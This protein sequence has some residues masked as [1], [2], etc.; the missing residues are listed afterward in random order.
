MPGRPERPTHRGSR[1]EGNHPSPW[2]EAG[3]SAKSRNNCGCVQALASS[4]IARK[5]RGDPKSIHRTLVTLQSTHSAH[6][7]IAIMRKSG[8]R[9]SFLELNV[10]LAHEWIIWQEGPRVTPGVSGPH[11]MHCSLESCKLGEWL[12]QLM[13]PLPS[14]L[15]T[16]IT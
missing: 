11:I 14:E 16:N 15:F 4:T 6:E 12:I 8:E 13:L 10:E 3:P 9:M 1:L 7:P 2:L 5:P